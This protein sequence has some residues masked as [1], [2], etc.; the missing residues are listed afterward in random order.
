M[1][2]VDRDTGVVVADQ[3]RPAH[4]HWTRM[5]GLL[6]TRSLP[7]GHGLWIKPCNQIHM[8]F[9]T[10]AVDLVFLDEDLRV[11]K[12]ISNQP[13]SSISPKVAQAE[14]VIEL[15]VG[16][17]DRAGLREGAL[18]AIE[19]QQEGRESVGLLE[20]LGSWS[21]NL[22]M[23]CLY[24]VFVYNHIRIASDFGQWSTTTPII[25]QEAIL[26]FLFLSRRRTREVSSR[27][28]DWV[29]GIAGTALPL[30]L[31]PTTEVS[32][33]A[34]LAQPVQ[35]IGLFLA[36]LGT[37]S[38]GRSIGVVAGNRGVKTAGMHSVVRHP[39]YL[40]YLVGYIAYGFVYPS[41][42]NLLI[43]VGTVLA[44]NVR[45]IAEERFLERD[46]VYRDYLQRVRYR[47]VPFLY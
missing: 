29:V 33:I 45:A 23:S 18:L 10:Y 1:R 11:V 44:L 36:L 21:G 3:L 7:E 27:P 26:V 13:V 42:R 47:F 40:G 6:G 31:W 46:P 16:S 15:P 8:Y 9:M 32:R 4:T 24:G 38:I 37:L 41:L 25:L 19:G 14:S 12:L 5:K 20:R 2:V 22:A 28:L 39:M 17:V 34:W 30:F 35:V 43:I